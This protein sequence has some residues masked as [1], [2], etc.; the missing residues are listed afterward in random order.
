[1]TGRLTR[2]PMAAPSVHDRATPSLERGAAPPRWR[3]VLALPSLFMLA[4]AGYALMVLATR[5]YNGA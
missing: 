2:Y 1:M 4:L 3:G 5:L